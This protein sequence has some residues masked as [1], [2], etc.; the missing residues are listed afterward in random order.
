[1]VVCWLVYMCWMV[2]P[3][4][5]LMAVCFA[6]VHF[7]I[8]VA[9][10]SVLELKRETN[11]AMSPIM[12]N[13]SEIGHCRELIQLMGYHDVF[14]HRHFRN[15][16]RFLHLTFVT[17]S[18][19][20]WTKMVGGCAA[21]LIGAF[22]VTFILFV[23]SSSSSSDPGQVGITVAYSLTVPSL[24]SFLYYM[25][26]MVSLFL[27]SLERFVE[28]QKVDQE[29]SWHHG[30]SDEKVLAAAWPS[31]G[32]ISF[33]NAAL[34]Y[35][36]ELPR[37]LDGV[38]FDLPGGSRTGVVGRTG[39]GKSSLMLLLFRILEPETGVVTIDGVDICSVGLH[40]LRKHLAIIPQHSLLLRG[41][42]R[43]NLDPFGERPDGELTRVLQRVGLGKD[44][45][46]L[47]RDLSDGSAGIR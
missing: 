46:M 30:P 35:R 17:Q 26:M 19:Q 28:Y 12:T 22:A 44:P 42:V 8:G 21:L 25:K 3:L 2:P 10:K 1:M 39:A 32:K 18:V 9:E 37:A 29:A 47:D 38:T 43:H 7:F 45:G 34:R 14:L 24:L 4:V 31:A 5:A 33:S 20:N 23:G 27:L 6:L 11:N 40:T 36:P 15:S 13:L 16:N 41:T